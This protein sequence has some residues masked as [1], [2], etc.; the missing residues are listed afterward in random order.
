MN[1]LG[2]ADKTVNIQL[3][4]VSGGEGLAITPNFAPYHYAISIDASSSIAIHY[5]TREPLE[6][7]YL[8]M[9]ELHPFS[10][11][12]KKKSLPE[13]VHDAAHRA[14]KADGSVGIV[15]VFQ[16]I[17]FLEHVHFEA[18][19]SG[20]DIYVI[21]E[22]HIQCGLP[23]R[24]QTIEIFLAWV[25]KH[26]LEPFEVTYELKERSGTRTLQLTENGDATFESL[27][28][29]RY[30]QRGIS[31]AQKARIEKKA[32]KEREILVWINSHEDV[33]CADCQSPVGRHNFVFLERGSQYCLDCADLGHLEFL[34]SGDATLTRRAKKFSPLSALVMEFNRRRKRNERRGILVTSEAIDQ[35]EAACEADADKRAEQRVKASARRA[36]QD[37]E[38]VEEMAA[39][40]RRLYPR[41]PAEEAT[42]IAAHTAERG[43]GRVGRSAAG[44]DLSEDAIHL[45]VQAWVRHQHT[46]Y[47]R[48]LMSGVE[49]YDAREQI[50]ATVMRKL[51][52][53]A[54]K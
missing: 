10:N 11:P 25:E 15:D 29:T 46:P 31:E 17:Q 26:N 16:S 23:K 44:R 24:Q 8:P 36:E 1:L 33:V 38:L 35:A 39:I 54:Q 6:C 5:V 22:Q 9:N 50:R 43:S 14:L 42:A 49:R 47:D 28:C 41:C 20:S 30:R 53:W 4:R 19:K 27:L 3:W 32:N 13:R 48:L 40:I 7:R 34:P 12:R 21:L 37:V 52:S 51:D 45:A 2:V 18:W